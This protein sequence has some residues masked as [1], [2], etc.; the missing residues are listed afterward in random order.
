V[1][2]TLCISGWISS[3]VSNRL[4]FTFN[5]IFGNRRKSQGAK[6]GEYGELRTCF[7]NLLVV[8]LWRQHLQ[9]YC[10]WRQVTG[11]FQCHYF[12]LVSLFRTHQ[13]IVT[14]IDWYCGMLAANI[15]RNT[16]YSEW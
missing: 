4:P 6:S 11:V 3:V 1:S 10:R 16:G 12:F 15:G 13:Y 2:S 8:Y 7:I 9:L 5:F 14:D